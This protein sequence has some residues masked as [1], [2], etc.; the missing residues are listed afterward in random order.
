MGLSICAAFEDCN[1]TISGLACGTATSLVYP[2]TT[3]GTRDKHI[4][5][6]LRGNTLT[7]S[8]SAVGPARQRHPDVSE[9]MRGPYLTDIIPASMHSFSFSLAVLALADASLASMMTASSA[10]LYMI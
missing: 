2:T 10:F 8:M 7:D 1:V 3:T 6:M 4:Y 5:G 9:N